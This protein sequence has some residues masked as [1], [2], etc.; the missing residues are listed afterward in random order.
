MPKAEELTCI[1][2]ITNAHGV[3][4]DV[5][6]H[7]LT[8]DIGF[9]VDLEEAYLLEKTGPRLVTIENARVHKKVVLIKIKTIDD[10]DAALE[11][12]DLQLLVKDDDLRPLGEGEYFI[13]NLLGSKVY[14]DEGDFLGVV[15]DYIQT[16]ESGACDVEREEGDFMFPTSK[17]VLL[18]VNAEEKKLVIHVIEGLLDL[19]TKP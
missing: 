7:P 19:N 9:L 13:H 1:G 10:M 16:G 15:K 12:K 6:V 4:G 14:S 11:L 8:D 18:E 5:K 3:R 2:Q 17:E